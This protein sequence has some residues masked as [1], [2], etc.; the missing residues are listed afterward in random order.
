MVLDFN[1]TTLAIPVVHGRVVRLFERLGLQGEVQFL[2]ARVNGQ[3]DTW[4]ILNV[5][6]IIRCIDDERCEQVEY[7]KPEDDNPEKVGQYRVVA[8]MRID[9]GKVE[10]IHIF[11]PWGWRVVMVVSQ[12]LKQALEEEGVTGMRFTDVT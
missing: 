10:G 2:P 4:F 6:K 7:W 11:R 5:L 3:A 1:L 12:Y 9:A 8:G